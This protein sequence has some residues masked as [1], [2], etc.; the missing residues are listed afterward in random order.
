[1][2]FGSLSSNR[3]IPFGTPEFVLGFVFPSF[4]FSLIYFVYPVF[5]EEATKISLNYFSFYLAVHNNW[6]Q[7][8]ESHTICIS[9]LSIGILQ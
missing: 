9:S 1:M 5:G 8:D 6:F 2:W 4:S 7:K 3:T